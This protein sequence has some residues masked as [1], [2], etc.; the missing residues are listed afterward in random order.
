MTRAQRKADLRDERVRRHQEGG[1]EG[2]EQPSFLERLESGNALDPVFYSRSHRYVNADWPLDARTDGASLRLAEAWLTWVGHG[3]VAE[4][5][6]VTVTS[7]V[8][9]PGPGGRP[10]PGRGRVRGPCRPAGWR[11]PARPTSRST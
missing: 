4:P 9:R 2:T 7:W 5:G 10:R 8:R 3:P 6:G 11:T 1:R